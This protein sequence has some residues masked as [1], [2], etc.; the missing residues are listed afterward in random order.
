MSVRIIGLSP[1]SLLEICSET[2]AYATCLRHVYGAPMQV[3][4]DSRGRLFGCLKK[5]LERALG[6][7]GSSPCRRCCSHGA[8]SLV[9]GVGKG[10][11]PEESRARAHGLGAAFGWSRISP[12]QSFS[13]T[14][15]KQRKSRFGP[16][17]LM[18]SPVSRC[19][20]PTVFHI[21]YSPGTEQMER[22]IAGTLL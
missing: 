14:A 4:R 21:W 6:I 22:V 15:L 7:N 3:K 11:R 18:A 9:K 13:L 16:A 8:G 5:V 2:Q 1:L 17:W 12:A 20:I 10:L 19:D